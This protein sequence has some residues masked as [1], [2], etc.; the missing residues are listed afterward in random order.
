MKKPKP[1]KYPPRIGYLNGKF[2]PATELKFSPYD[3]GSMYGVCVFEMTRS[4]KG[5]TFRLTE[6]ILRL[7]EGL[8]VLGI[9]VKEA[10]ARM[11]ELCEA[12]VKRNHFAPDDEHRLMINVTPGPL[13]IYPGPHEP[14]VMIDD[15]PLRWTVRGMGRMFD[16]GVEA[17]VT[18]QKTAPFWAVDP[19]IKN[20]SRLHYWCATQEA[21]GKWAILTDQD[22][23]IAE[24]A[25]ANIFI[26]KRGALLSPH[27]H[28]ALA[29]ISRDY[30]L[31]VR[32]AWPYSMTPR[33]LLTADEAFFTA[34]P[35]CA[36][37]ITKVNGMKIGDGRP[38]PFFKKL[39]AG[40][41]EDVGVDIIEQIKDW[42]RDGNGKLVSSPYAV[43][44]ARA[45]NRKH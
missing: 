38:G 23:F 20:R 11:M 6:H 18:R 35:F 27:S 14:T 26:V 37:P 34:T 5:R 1:Y 30:V 16:R 3:A 21:R 32:A 24:G 25:G 2:V 45:R 15:F 44:S 43:Q 17:V 41:S 42:D 9:E 4:F 10:P 28:N 12:V 36:L 22:G 29:G 13:G 8:K 7:Y 31:A 39:M 19:R 33:D 40:W